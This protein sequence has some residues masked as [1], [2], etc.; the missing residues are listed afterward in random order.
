[1]SRSV[2]ISVL[3]V[4]ALA[5]ICG[6]E[7]YSIFS[8]HRN[9]AFPGHQPVTKT[10]DIHSNPALIQ[11]KSYHVAGNGKTDDTDHIRQA[12]SAAAAISGTVF[13]GK[14]TYLVSGPIDIPSNVSIIGSGKDQ[15]IF[16]AAKRNNDH[17]FSLGGN[18]TVENVSFDSRLGIMP[19]G[20]GIT[21]DGCKFMSS[22]QG[23]QNAVTVHYLTVINCLF[24]KSGYG[25]LSNQQPSYDVKV[26]NCRF[27][28]NYG[29]AV[30]INASSD[31]WVIENCTFSGIS[32]N[33]PNAGFGVGAAISAKNIVIKGCTFERIDGQGVHAEDHSQVAIIN[34]AFRNN[35][36]RNYPG[37]PKADIAVLSQAEVFID[38]SFFL[39]SDSNYSKLAIYNTDLPVGGSVT[40]NSS[41]FYHKSIGAPI[42]SASNRFIQ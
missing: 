3:L 2:R 18:Q 19:A 42:T 26:I 17:I 20:D 13:F 16:K 23:I 14:G 28:N 24:E 12:I 22:V 6:L 32:S 30:E 40:V 33:T 8:F 41:K 36:F 21:I 29:D 4:A 10:L 11:A 5:V 27:I 9:A 25:I 34:C 39:A 31:G 37:S 15:T 38:H 1:M 7:I 35:G